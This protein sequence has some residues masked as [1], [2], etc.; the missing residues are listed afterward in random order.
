MVVGG[1]W[2]V[3]GGLMEGCA[4][5]HLQS[6]LRVSVPAPQASGKQRKTQRRKGNE[7][8]DRMEG[9]GKGAGERGE[10]RAAGRGR[11]RSD[12]PHLYASTF[13]PVREYVLPCTRVRS[14]LYGSTFSLYERTVWGLS[15]KEPPRQRL[16]MRSRGTC[17]PTAKWITSEKKGQTCFLTQNTTRRSCARRA[18]SGRTSSLERR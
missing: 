7:T 9:A 12:R 16:S 17:D 5:A 10:A 1:W 8:E 18:A 6:N 15:H 11:R 2:L 4:Q 13:T 3:V 14:P